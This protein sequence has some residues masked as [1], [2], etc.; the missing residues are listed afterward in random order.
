MKNLL[1]DNRLVI[2]L[3]LAVICVVVFIASLL[4]HYGDLKETVTVSG[5][6]GDTFGGLFSPIIGL[7]TVLLV[8]RTFQD[9]R[10]SNNHAKS[11]TNLDLLLKIL[12]RHQQNLVIQIPA[13]LFNPTQKAVPNRL[14]IFFYGPDSADFLGQLIEKLHN[15]T[16]LAESA[17][18][19]IFTNGHKA[20]FLNE[21]KNVLNQYFKHY[22]P[23]V[24]ELFDCIQ[25]IPGQDESSLNSFIKSEF[26]HENNVFISRV[27]SYT[28]FL[29]SYHNLVER[30]KILEIIKTN[31]NEELEPKD[32]SLSEPI[33]FDLVEKIKQTKQFDIQTTST[34]IA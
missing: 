15:L 21:V 30:L 29:I 11:A 17:D 9:Q 2:N 3:I 6:L 13:S 12:E 18:T 19:F 16:H 34:P 7:I 32:A 20:I 8:Y 22:H 26:N 27:N 1:K 28:N 14:D 31:I 33:R 23:T 10:T 24:N 4:L 5:P 25:Y